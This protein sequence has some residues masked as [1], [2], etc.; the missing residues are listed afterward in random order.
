VSL[1]IHYEERATEVKGK[2]Y[3][4]L[5]FL[6]TALLPLAGLLASWLVGSWPEGE[7]S[8]AAPGLVLMASIAGLLLSLLSILL[9]E[10]YVRHT[11][12][13]FSKAN[14]IKKLCPTL[15]GALNTISTP[16][17]KPW[18]KCRDAPA[19]RQGPSPP[20]QVFRGLQIFSGLAF[21]F[22]VLA[23]TGVF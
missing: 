8:K 1:W 16:A 22:F 18:W 15:Q 10:D 2:M 4:T 13:A 17:P 23:A 11:Q 20:E 19:D 7:A 3:G 12:R 21:A 6:D 5:T 14:E 9:A